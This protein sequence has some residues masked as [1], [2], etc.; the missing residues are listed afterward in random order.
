MTNEERLAEIEARA[1]AVPPGP[2]ARK[3]EE[4]G[5][6]AYAAADGSVVMDVD[7]EGGAGPWIRFGEWGSLRGVDV[8]EFVLHARSDIDWLIAR[9]RDLEAAVERYESQDHLGEDQ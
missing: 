6:T 1:Q 9:V 4:T 8:E 2:W 7:E 3:G 5:D